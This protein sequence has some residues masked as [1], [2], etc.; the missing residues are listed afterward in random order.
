MHPA[1]VVATDAVPIVLLPSI[2]CADDV[3]DGDGEVGHSCDVAG[4]KHA[5]FKFCNDSGLRCDQAGAAT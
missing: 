5:E 1:T 4:G 2:A 3:G